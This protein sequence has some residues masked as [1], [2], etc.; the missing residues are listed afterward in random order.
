MKLHLLLGA[1]VLF[2]VMSSCQE[3]RKAESDPWSLVPAQSAWVAQV[4]QP[5]DLDLGQGLWTSLRQSPLWQD[6]QAQW[7]P[8]SQAIPADSMTHWLRGRPLL[9]ASVLSGAQRYDWL[10]LLP[11]DDGLEKSLLR[12]WQSLEKEEAQYA[13]SKILKIS[14]GGAEIYLASAEGLLLVGASRLAVEAALRQKESPLKL[15]TQVE[16]TALKKLSNTKNPINIYLQSSEFSPLLRSYFP[17]AQFDFLPRSVEWAQLDLQWRNRDLF[18]TGAAILPPGPKS[19]LSSFKD[20]KRYRS[21]AAAVVPQNFGFWFQLN[22]G[23]VEQY[24]R[25]YRTH[26]ENR[27]QLVAYEDRQALLPPGSVKSLESIVDY[28]IGLF[29]AGF[30]GTQVSSFGYLRLRDEEAARNVLEALSDTAFVEGHRGY[31]LRRLRTQNLLARTFGVVFSALHQPYYLIYQDYVLLSEDRAALKLVLSD[32]L[33]GKSLQESESYRKLIAQVPELA[34]WRAIS[35]IP[36]AY[37]SWLPALA[38][39]LQGAWEQAQDSL[40]ALK[41]S[42]WQASVEEENLLISGILRQEKALQERI[43][44]LWT[45]D[46]PAPLR[47]APQLLKNHVNQKWDI[48]VSDEEHQ[49]HYL[50]RQGELLWSKPLDGPILGEIQQVD[51]YKNNKYQLLFNTANKIYLVDRLGRDVEGFPLSLPHAASAPMGLFDYDQ[52]RN[53]RIIV[54]AGK[55]LLNYDIE[56]QAVKGWAFEQADAALVTQPQHFSV[57]GRDL[58]VVMSEKGSLYQLNRRGDARFAPLRNLEALASPFF[59]KA[60]EALQA[61]ELMAINRQGELYSLRPSG[62]V[63]AVYLDRSRPADFFLYREGNYIFSHRNHL[64][65]QSEAQPFSVSFDGDIS[66]VPQLFSR[67]EQWYLAAYS[68]AAE[69]IR[70]F[71]AKGQLLQGFP[72][73]A[74][75]PFALGALHRDTHLH[76]ITYSRDGTLICYQL[77]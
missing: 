69:E 34:H 71:N 1:A 39:N 38:P 57:G 58:I 23:N 19:Y 74:Q 66:S 29:E 5:Q 67:D 73:F 48:A 46:L 40:E 61:S 51:R 15:S 41:W 36:K 12:A 47:G 21:G 22:V 45:T 24:L 37:R 72:I 4:N 25:Q 43:S 59:L 64:V 63:D 10:I 3:G 33:D 77:Q 68:A 75:G 35:Q 9:L 18:F 27:G 65:V 56:G 14:K 50:S 11:T 55:D 62:L 60:E 30:S 32:L 54:P 13:Q 44:R 76:L 8:F 20:I 2:V 26:L 52:A 31:L 7:Q 70:L 28:E 53:Y 17:E 16:F 42:L 6:W 49:L